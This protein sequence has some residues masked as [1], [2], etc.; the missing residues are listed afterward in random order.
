MGWERIRRTGK[1][2]PRREYSSDRMEFAVPLSAQ[3]PPEWSRY[4]VDG[5]GHGGGD[6]EG[7][8]EPTIQEDT[9]LIAPRDG[10]LA[11]WVAGIEELIEGANEYYE[12]TVL[13]KLAHEER[14]RAEEAKRA[15]SRME[16]ARKEAEGIDGDTTKPGS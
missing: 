5:F 15:E 2:V 10:T 4:L 1:P 11:G 13:S 12:H 3:P 7:G 8:P 16:Q 14:A 6:F 9:I